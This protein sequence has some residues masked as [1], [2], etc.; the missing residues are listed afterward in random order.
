GAVENLTSSSDSDETDPAWSRDGTR[1]AFASDRGIDG[2]GR[3][4]YD[5]WVLDMKSPTTPIQITTNGSVDDRPIWD[6]A[7]EAI[8]FRSNRGGEW[9]IWRIAVPK[10]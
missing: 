10:P 4:N 7:G 9:A 6:P 1:I 2:E 8:Y 5:I 3:A